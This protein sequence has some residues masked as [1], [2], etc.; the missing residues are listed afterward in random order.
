[1]PQPRLTWLNLSANRIANMGNFAGHP[2]L[3]SLLIAEN[4]LTSV[5]S[6]KAMA[7]LTE[8]DISGNQITNL[9][10]MEALPCL[11]TLNAAKNKIDT[12]DKFPAFTKLVTLSLEENAI[13]KPGML[14]HL[15]CLTSLKELKMNGNPW[16][17][18]KGDDFKKEVLIALDNLK[19]KF[20]NGAEE[21]VTEEER[22]EAAA[23]KAERIKAA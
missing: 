7:Q 10:D 21:E 13:D 22:Q 6:F 14:P 20:I 15:R 12:L 3:K 9:A 18:E 17:D 19:V 2:Y 5:A 11:R 4:K 23:E 1:M 8:L 16:V